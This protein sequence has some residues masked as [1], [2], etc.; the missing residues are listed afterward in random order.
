MYIHKYIYV[1]HINFLCSGSA[2]IYGKNKKPTTIDGE[3]KNEQDLGDIVRDDT[4][5]TIES[6]NNVPDDVTS[7]DNGKE[8]LGDLVRDDTT[9][10]VH[11]GED[12]SA[13][14]NK[15]VYF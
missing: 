4:V 14:R 5:K 10:S 9:K 13:P 3:A 12:A 2:T 7:L 1:A 15:Y 11:L 8:D 6:T